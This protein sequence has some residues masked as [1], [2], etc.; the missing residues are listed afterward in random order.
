MEKLGDVVAEHGS[1]SGEEFAVGHTDGSPQL[2]KDFFLKVLVLF[3]DES[4]RFFAQAGIF[5]V[6]GLAHADGLLDHHTHHGLGIL[7][8]VVDSSIDLFPEAWHT[9][10][11]V[12]LHFLDGTLDFL[13]VVVD[14]HTDACT[15]THHGPSQFKDMA[16]RQETQRHIGL[17]VDDG[18]KALDVG[19]HGR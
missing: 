2:A 12:G 4:G 19:I 8:V 3:L 7:Q 18:V 16:E 15:Q 5:H 17:V 10:H 11:V 6:P 14:G 9:A 1:G 13:G